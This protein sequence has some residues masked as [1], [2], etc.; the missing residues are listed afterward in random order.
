MPFAAIATIGGGL[1]SGNQA[2]K[3]AGQTARATIEA[4]RIGA[5]AQKFRPVGTTTAFG[6][7]QFGFTPEGYL[8]SAGYQLSPEMARQRD[9]LLQ[10][11]GTSG[12][13]MAEQAGAAGQG[14]FN[15]G[16][17]YLAQSPEAAAQQWLRTQQAALAPGQEQ[18]LANI[19]NQ[20]QQQGRTG[21]AV[22]A[23]SAGGLGASNPQ[24]QAY[25]NSLALTNTDLAAKAQEQGRAQTTFGQGLL[26]AGIDITSLGYNPYK[27]QFGLAQSLE[28]AGQ[29]ALDIGS[30]LGGRAASAG[31]NVGNTLFAGGRAA[32]NAMYDANAYSPLGTAISGLGNSPRLMSGIQNY[33]GNAP[34]AQQYGTN[35][36]SQ[37]T[38]ML[39]EQDSWFR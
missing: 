26:G 18:T 28:S 23:T 2:S 36:G 22:G 7:S 9:L 38:Q 17:G 13:G 25:Y 24:L 32:A 12:L 33:F 19:L 20:Q 16:Q 21:L 5:E 15:L 29:G 11:A 34:T 30:S 3:A 31:A 1:I 39:A 8:S 4:A 35:V 37:Q 10:Q 27:T 14:L 6:S